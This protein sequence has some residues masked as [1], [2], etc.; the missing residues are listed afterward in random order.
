MFSAA[1][2]GLLAANKDL[3]APLYERLLFTPVTVQAGD[4]G[5]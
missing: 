4:A 1:V 5:I 2:I 3:L